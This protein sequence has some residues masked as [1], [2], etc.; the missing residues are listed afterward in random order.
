MELSSLDIVGH[1]KQPVPNT[2]ITQP[3]PSTHL[4]VILPGYR[5]PVEMPP[6]HYA[7]RLLLE[8]GA[9]VLRVEYA[10]YRTNFLQQAE[11]EQ[12][13]WISDDVFAA[14]DAG[15]SQRSYEKITLVGQ[16]LGTIAMVHLL[17]D[18]RFQQVACVW[19]TPLLTVEWLRSRIEEIRPRSLFI[20][21]TAD[22][23]YNPELLNHLKTVTQGQTCIL[24]GADHGLEIPGDIPGSLAALHQIVETLQAFL[25]EDTKTIE[26]NVDPGEI[27]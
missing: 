16:S 23:F 1:K 13:Q 6:L 12:D 7:A 14:C 10:Y 15:L 2:F 17:S 11:S 25:N 24:E 20:I 22:R 26:Q 18:H 8:Q 9:D 5:Y 21:G 3:Q 27:T 4:A 19:V